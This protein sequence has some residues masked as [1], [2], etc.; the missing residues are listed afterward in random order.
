MGGIALL[1][2][3]LHEVHPKIRRYRKASGK[4]KDITFS[5]EELVLRDLLVGKASLRAHVRKINDI[6]VLPRLVDGFKIRVTKVESL[7]Y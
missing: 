4:K 5:A 2:K 1:R 3:R 7:D 6:A